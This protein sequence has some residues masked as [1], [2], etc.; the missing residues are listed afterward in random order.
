MSI[1]VENVTRRFGDFLAVDN[2]SLDVPPGSL[3]AL[4]GLMAIGTLVL[5]MLFRPKEEAG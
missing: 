1:A 4:L 2:V 3:T 5:M